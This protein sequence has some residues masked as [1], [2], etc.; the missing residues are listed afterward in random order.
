MPVIEDAGDCERWLDPTTP[1]DK[2]LA[3]LDSRP[4]D[5]IEVVPVNVAVINP[6]NKGP[7]LLRPV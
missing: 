3:L 2:M 7:E 5:G 6:R 1:T 4:V